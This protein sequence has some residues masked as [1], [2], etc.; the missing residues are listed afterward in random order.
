[1]TILRKLFG[2]SLPSEA[3]GISK[4]VQS[5]MFHGIVDIAQKLV[6]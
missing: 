4:K 1:M 2:L 3:L 6:W 5:S